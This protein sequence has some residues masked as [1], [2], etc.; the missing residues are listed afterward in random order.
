MMGWLLKFI[1][2]ATKSTFL[3]QKRCNS[4]Q[5]LGI[6]IDES[7]DHSWPSCQDKMQ[8][9]HA[10]AA[11]NSKEPELHLLFCKGSRR[12]SVSLMSNHISRFPSRNCRVGQST[13][14][15]VLSHFY[16]FQLRQ[17][18]MTLGTTPNPQGLTSTIATS[19]NDST[20]SNRS[21]SFV[22]FFRE[23]NE[24]APISTYK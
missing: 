18:R 10:P 15:W 19:A 16:I 20:A 22:G 23:K 4:M 21:F 14:I 5:A 24:S 9:S 13:Q 2:Q 1:Y 3:C 8:K 11:S 12:I 17:G 7:Q 6:S